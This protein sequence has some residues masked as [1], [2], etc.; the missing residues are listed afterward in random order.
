MADLISRH[1]QNLRVWYGTAL[2]LEK[3]SFTTFSIITIQKGIF[4]KYIAEIN[5]KKIGCN[6]ENNAEAQIY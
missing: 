6:A 2:K 3:R 4:G 1:I 5:F